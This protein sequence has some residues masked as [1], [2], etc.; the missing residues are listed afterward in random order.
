MSELH[1]VIL[2]AGLGKR[3]NSDLPK[4][5]HLLAGRP[6]LSH[7]VDACRELGAAAVHVVYGHD[8]AR[9]RET[10]TDLDVRW[11][12]Q[13]QRLG[14]GHAVGQA[15]PGVPGDAMVLVLYGDVPLVNRQTLAEIV[16]LAR[17]DRLALLTVSLDDPTGY[18]RIIRD[19]RGK[20][21]EIVEEN[22]ATELQRGAREINTGI[23]AAPARRL[24][25]W[26]ERVGND[27]SQGEYYLTDV[28]SLA[29][30]DGVDVQSTQPATTDEVLGVNDRVQLAHLER[31]FQRRAAERL[32]H[33]GATVLDPNRLDI[34]GQVKVGR[35]VTIDVNVI[36]E[37][38]VELG[39]GA[40]IGSNV[41]IRDA[42]VGRGTHI[43]PN[44]VIEEAE[45]GG[46]CRIGP[47]ARIRPDTRL[48]DHVHVGNFVEI[49]NSVIGN[50]SKANHLSYIGDTE[51]GTGV[52]VGAGTITCNYDGANKHR[53]VIGDG[54][55]IGSGVEL[56]APVVINPGA[57][58]GAGSTIDRDAPEDTLT[59]ARNRQTTVPGWQRPVKN[60]RVR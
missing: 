58:I 33:D 59:V 36:L 46:E 9:V 31:A 38:R 51:I 44:T 14:T 11:V 45:I 24:S 16:R 8:G 23:V 48:A 37:G 15:L 28:L 10:M 18:G 57:T 25:G 34:R 56:V 41:R 3:M 20:L 5:L 60:S 13:A 12:E 4:V 26:L 32:M 7:V 19:E 2:A 52:N 47:F 40:S 54:A 21:L 53:T 6:L 39:E 50:S 29:V 27:N 1:V 55:F 49:K 22:D 17:D 43:L 42:S 35:D 30:A